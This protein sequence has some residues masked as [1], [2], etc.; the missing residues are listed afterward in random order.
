V[1][2]RRSYIDVFDDL[3]EESTSPP[4]V[5]G[6]PGRFAETVR[7][8]VYHEIRT[9]VTLSA[10]FACVL[11]VLLAAVALSSRTAPDPL[12]GFPRL[13][14]WAWERPERLAFVDP[15]STGVAFLARTIRWRGPSI[16]SRPRLQPLQVPPGTPLIA[17]V[18]L[19][20]V[21]APLP[22]PARVAHDIIESAA[23]PGVRAV[24]VDFDARRSERAWYRTL[25][26]QLRAGLP[27]SI[28][29]G[30]TA[31]LSW[32]E[33]DPWMSGLPVVEAVPMLFRLGPGES[34]PGGDFRASLCRSSV[35]V[36]SDELPRA[37]PQGRRV[38]FF[39]PRP[40][41]EASYRA[42]LRLFRSW[43]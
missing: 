1:F 8:A 33:L 16:E 27:A 25:L 5:T 23:W 7:R 2:I 12:P 37:V 6:R 4:G 31:L 20:S 10:K 35:G 43:Q 15:G 32:C 9:A 28:P 21:A 29:I 22:D 13:V 36:S 24:Q 11:V 40:W 19:E 34:Y 3:A 30:I 17:V 26:K 41:T 14:L 38:Y 18:R 39:H 42:A